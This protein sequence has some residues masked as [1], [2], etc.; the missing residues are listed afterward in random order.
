VKRFGTHRAFAWI[1]QPVSKLNGSAQMFDGAKVEIMGE[2]PYLNVRPAGVSLALTDD[3]R[4]RAVFLYSQDVEDFGQYADELPAGV[5]FADK[6]A[7]VRSSLGKPAMSGDAGGV[8]LMAIEFSFDRFETDERYL[9]FEY[10]PNDGAIR[11]VTIG[12]CEDE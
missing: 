12:S 9:R 7:D 1:D 11:L 2:S 6:R 5:S 3:H 10:R 8:G 4:V